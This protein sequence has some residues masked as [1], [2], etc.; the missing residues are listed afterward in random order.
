MQNKNAN[1]YLY[2]SKRERRGIFFM[3]F[4]IALIYISPDVYSRLKPVKTFTDLEILDIKTITGSTKDTARYKFKDE[5]EKTFSLFN[6]DPNT[7]SIEGWKN[8]GIKEKTAIGIH[9]YIS[10]GGKFNNADDI[11][12][13]WGI[14]PQKAEQLLPFIKINSPKQ[15]IL[16]YPKIEKK[17]ISKIDINK[18]DSTAFESLPGI[19][20]KLSQRIINF[21]QKL[22]GFYKIDQI[23][24]TFGL[25]DSTFQKI[26]PFLEISKF[27]L[28]KIDVNEAT[29]DDLKSHPYI[30]Y[31]I[32][33]A[34][35]KYRSQ[36]GNFTNI[37]DIKNIVLVTD[38]VFSKVNP[39]LKID[40]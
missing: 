25:P 29:I 27:E 14:S 33:N 24:E 16:Y 1:H 30:R 5:E 10:K 2:F 34:I 23:S 35:I 6:F 3:L 37:D 28:K 12:K 13:I 7:L 18:A 19:G 32:G 17:L 21:R 15:E 4:L 36:H 38:E 11:K 26:K 9:K 40:N 20:P 39:Y 22:G 8:L 31:Q